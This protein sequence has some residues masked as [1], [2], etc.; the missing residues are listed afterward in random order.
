MNDGLQVPKKK[1]FILFVVIT[2]IVLTLGAAKFF[3]FYQSTK[4]YLVIAGMLF[5]LTGLYQIEVSGFFDRI[6]EKYSDEEKYPY[7][8]PSHVTRTIIDDVDHPR[9]TWVSNYFFRNTKFGFNLIVVGT[10]L[11]IVDASL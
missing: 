5:Q 10:I 2:L 3:G 4:N 6:Y 7:G 11:Q 1:I 8:P 9:L